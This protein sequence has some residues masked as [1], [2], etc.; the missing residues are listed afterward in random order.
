MQEL[1]SALTWHHLTFIFGLVIILV[2][3]QPLSELI[4]RTTKIGKD[5]LMAGSSPESQR[6]K[7]DSEAVQQ[8][9]EAES[10]S[11]VIT[12]VENNIK[13]DL[14]NKGLDIA[15]STVKVLIRKLAVEKILLSFEQI[16]N[17]IFGSQIYL[18]KRLNEVTGQGMSLAF[19]NNHIDY[20]KSIY[21]SEL[22]Q[23]TYD[24]YLEFLYSYLLIVRHGDQIHI[25]E[26]GVEYLT[27]IARHGRRENNL[28]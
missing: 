10:N 2:F 8:L 4:R 25:T 14:K 15:G 12:K 20:I 6:E 17:R 13:A 22:G 7:P 26:S 9:L 19:V 16:H 5:G 11:I 21:P 18:L 3:K 28:F 1:L 27:W 24:Q 23:W